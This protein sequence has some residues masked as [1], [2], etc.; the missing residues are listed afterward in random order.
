M[1]DSPNF[2]YWFSGFLRLLGLSM[3]VI[4]PV[5]DTALEHNRAFLLLE[6]S[7][8]ATDPMLDTTIER[9]RA[10]LLL[11]L[12]VIALDLTIILALGR[13]ILKPCLL[14]LA[15]NAALAIFMLTFPRKLIED[16]RAIS[17]DFKNKNQAK[18]NPFV[19]MSTI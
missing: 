1:W 10:F 8:I 19:K 12:S 11:E 2:P 4:D 18:D 14:A 6:L 17:L 5:L 13:N 9:R 7:V 16:E 3:I 15:L